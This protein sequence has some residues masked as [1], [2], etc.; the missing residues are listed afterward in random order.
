MNQPSRSTNT[1]NTD[2]SG[3]TTLDAAPDA[4][5][6][7][8]QEGWSETGALNA[9]SGESGIRSGLSGGS[10][11]GQSGSSGPSS[12]GSYAAAAGGSSGPVGGSS[13]S[14][15]SSGEPSLN[16][17]NAPNSSYTTDIGGKDDPGRAALGGM[18]AGNVPLPTSGTTGGREGQV[19]GDGQFDA[20][21]ETSA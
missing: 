11:Q 18:Q 1:N 5:A 10:S 3:A 2:T 9:A 19:T 16:D 21:D 20:L 13:S 7:A 17:G 8:A 6:R 14:A 12:G 4:E 15:G